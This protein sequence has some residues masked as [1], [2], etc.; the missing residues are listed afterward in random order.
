MRIFEN[1]GLMVGGCVL[2]QV[3][4]GGC[5]L[6]ESYG[7]SKSQSPHSGLVLNHTRS[8]S[9]RVGTLPH[10]EGVCYPSSPLHQTAGCHTAARRPLH[11]EYIGMSKGFVNEGVEMVDDSHHLARPESRGQGGE[12]C[13]VTVGR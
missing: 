8:L 4:A 11:V 13:Y 1:E 10:C 3:V 2:S 12:P 9:W 6:R 5:V 7:V